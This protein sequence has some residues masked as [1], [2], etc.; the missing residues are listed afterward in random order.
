MSEEQKEVNVLESLNV[1]LAHYKA[2]RDQFQINLQQ[3]VGAI[4][5]TEESIKKLQDKC[6]AEEA[7]ELEPAEA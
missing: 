5:A 1:D 2:Q 4:F 7:A 6:K 3:C